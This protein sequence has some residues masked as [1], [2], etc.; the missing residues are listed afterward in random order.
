M[1]AARPVFKI[2]VK[3]AKPVPA[4]GHSCNLWHRE[5]LFGLG[6]FGQAKI[7]KNRAQAERIA[8]LFNRPGLYDYSVKEF[9][10]D[11]NDTWL[12]VA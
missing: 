4:C 5:S 1:T 11:A 9:V 3:C 12:E 2:F 10:V 7:F 6:T 8:A